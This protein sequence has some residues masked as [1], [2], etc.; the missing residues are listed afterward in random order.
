M[1]LIASRWRTRPRPRIRADNA[2]F[3]LK[4]FDDPDTKDDAVKRGGSGARESFLNVSV[5]PA[6]PRFVTKVLEQQSQ[7]VRVD[8]GLGT[9]TAPGAAHERRRRHLG[10]RRHGRSAPPR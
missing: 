5:D 3:N 4:V 2:L 10:H 6:S 1:N 7:L 9:T 8:S